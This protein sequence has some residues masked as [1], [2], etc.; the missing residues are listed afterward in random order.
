MIGLVTGCATQS[1]IL[2]ADQ[3]DTGF[4]S[5]LPCF[6]IG[7][8]VESEVLPVYRSVSAFEGAA[9]VSTTRV[10][11]EAPAGVETLRL[12]HQA[13]SGLTELAAVQSAVE[14]QAREFC[15][16]K[17][18]AAEKLQITTSNPFY[19]MGNLPRVELIFACV[20]STWQQLNPPY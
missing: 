13:A 9:H 10:Y 11:A 17:E 7:C 20:D 1:S 14:R 6:M 5:H 12:F 18:Q 8:A 19:I 2:P 3:R 4:T 16:E 15:Y